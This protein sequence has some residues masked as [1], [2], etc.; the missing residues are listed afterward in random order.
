MNGAELTHQYEKKKGYRIDSCAEDQF[1]LV[2]HVAN[3]GEYSENGGNLRR[4][5]KVIEISLAI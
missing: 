4:K 1:R 2:V 3:T 5:E